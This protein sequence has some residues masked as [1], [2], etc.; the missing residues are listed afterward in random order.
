LG[1]FKVNGPV[2]LAGEVEISGSKNSSLPII[3]ASLISLDDVEIRNVPDLLDVRTMIDILESINFDIKFSNGI[4][5][6]KP[7]YSGVNTNVPYKLVRKMRASF[8]VLGPLAARY[9]KA[10]V[11]LPGGCSIGVRPV[12]F[13][14]KGLEKLG[15]EVNIEH[16]FVE[17]KLIKPN[18]CKIILPKPSVGATEH[19]MTTAAAIDGIEVVIENAA[20]EPEIVDLQEFLKK[21]GVE[22]EG[23]GTSRITIKGGV[24]KRKITHEVIPDRIEAGSYVI[25]IAATGGEGIIKNINSE[26]LNSLWEVLEKVGVNLKIEKNQVHVKM[27]GIPKPVDINV[28]PYPGFPTDLQPQIMALL[29]LADGTSY[30]KE[31]VFQTRFLHVD[32][33]KRMGAEIEITDGTAIIKGVKKLSGAPVNGTDLRATAALL[34]AAFMANGK[35]EIHHVE[36]IFRGYENV[37]EK[38]QKLGGKIEYVGVKEYLE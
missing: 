10:K 25:A 28:S 15:F 3:A 27:N 5:H 29:T 14:I 8:N 20:M 31:N 4:V 35:S 18:S 22:I 11:A 21:L 34:I 38:F 24:K 37:C 13:H 26:H 2:K 30:I 6:V 1:Y 9:G 19:L 32:E 16:G 17:A 36:H 23:A 12:N 33:L 7:Q